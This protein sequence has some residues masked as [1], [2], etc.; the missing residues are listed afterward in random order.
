MNSLTLGT[1]LTA[2]RNTLSPVLQKQSIG[3]KQVLDVLNARDQ[4]DI[5]LTQSFP[6]GTYFLQEIHLLDCQLKEHA[7][8]ITSRL[9]FAAYRQS[10]AKTPEQ[11]WWWL[12]ETL[13]APQKHP[14]DWVIQRCDDTSLGHQHWTIAQ[15]Q[16][17]LFTGRGRG[18]G[19]LGHCIVE[20][21]DPIEGPQ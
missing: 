6:P 5:I 14:T 9:N 1:A 21:A 17:S 20:F 7:A 12:D 3:A 19:A 15:Y 18:S 8:T 10:F 2:Y 11:W 16:R 4:L 13:K